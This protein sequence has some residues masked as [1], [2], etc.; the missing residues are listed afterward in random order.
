[1]VHIVGLGKAFLFHQSPFLQY[2]IGMQE[3]VGGD[4][5]D[6]AMLRPTTEQRLQYAGRRALADRDAACN[7]D[8]IGDARAMGAEELLQHDLS[9]DA[10]AE[11]EIQ[12][13]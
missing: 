5:L 1:M 13:A 3:P 6:P 2:F 8:N 12:Q 7:A 10:G 4:Q 11:I 9:T